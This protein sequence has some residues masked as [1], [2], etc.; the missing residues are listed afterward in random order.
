MSV[1]AKLV[2]SGSS[3]IVKNLLTQATTNPTVNDD[4][5]S[6]FFNGHKWHNTASSKVYEL[7]DETAGA[8]VWIELTKDDAGGGS[9]TQKAD[10]SYAG[11]APVYAELNTTLTAIG[12]WAFARK[13]GS[14]SVYQVYRNSISNG[15]I[16]DFRSVE[17][18]G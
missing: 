3:F 13:D 1:V 15:D 10:V 16:N 2:V 14:S 7:L 17:L 6:G 8:A 18:T 12:D 5:N 9:S 4:I 11:T